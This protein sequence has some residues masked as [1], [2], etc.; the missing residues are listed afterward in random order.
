MKRVLTFFKNLIPYYKKHEAL[1]KEV[2]ELKEK[3]DNSQKVINKT[4]AYWK[5]KFYQKQKAD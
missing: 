3:L 5:K 4:N 2:Q 1:I